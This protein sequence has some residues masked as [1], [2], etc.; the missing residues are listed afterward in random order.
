MIAKLIQPQASDAVL[1]ACFSVYK[2]RP[3]KKKFRVG[4]LGYGVLWL[5]IKAVAALMDEHCSQ[6][7]NYLNATSCPVGLLVNFG[8]FPKVEFERTVFAEKRTTAA[9]FPS[10]NFS[11]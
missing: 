8:S 5:E 2:G 1:G 3:L 11:F 6:V 7:L 10:P 9:Q 4:F